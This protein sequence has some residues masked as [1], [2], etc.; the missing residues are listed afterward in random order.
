MKFIFT[1]LVLFSMSTSSFAMFSN[2]MLGEAISC[3][4]GSGFDVTISKNRAAI[5][6]FHDGVKT[7]YNVV[8]SKHPASDGDTF[9]TYVGIN[10]SGSNSQKA[11]LSFDDM[12]DNL[13]LGGKTLLLLECR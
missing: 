5:I 10:G 6:V 3:H 1:A 7:V 4:N 13:V 11:T 12:G 9:I 2:D 8:N